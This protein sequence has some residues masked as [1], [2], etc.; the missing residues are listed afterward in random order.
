M[1]R[2]IVSATHWAPEAMLAREANPGA[3]KSSLQ[4]SFGSTLTT[5]PYK[6]AANHVTDG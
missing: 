1:Q 4:V 5:K 3:A 2:P 6:P